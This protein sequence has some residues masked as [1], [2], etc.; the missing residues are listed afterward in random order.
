MEA[1]P[2]LR[3][4]RSPLVLI[5]VSPHS[6]PLSTFSSALDHCFACFPSA[7]SLVS[8]M[9]ES[10]APKPKHLKPPR[11]SASRRRQHSCHPEAFLISIRTTDTPGHT[12]DDQ[13]FPRALWREPPTGVQ[14]PELGLSGALSA[15]FVCLPQS[16]GR[17]ESGSQAQTRTMR[18]RVMSGSRGCL[19]SFYFQAA[20]LVS[21][22][23]LGFRW[24]GGEA[25]VGV[26]NRC[27]GFSAAV[28]LPLPEV[29][30]CR[31]SIASI[32]WLKQ[33]KHRLLQSCRSEAPR[34][35][36]W[37]AF[38]PRGALLSLRWVL[39]EFGSLRLGTKIHAPLLAV[40]RRPFPASRDTTSQAHAPSSIVKTSNRRSRALTL[41]MSEPLP[42]VTPAKPRLPG[43]V[44]NG[45]WTLKL[46]HL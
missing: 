5:S 12:T 31:L 22:F 29:A 10:T 7:D 17:Q 8:S 38:L 35:S 37:A 34:G 2:F 13:V 44:T 15:D 11:P 1:L 21:L 40:S 46:R 19:W 20:E 9:C 24:G 39:A 45:F 36:P 33:H 30:V 18:P 32:W 23:T 41:P 26:V 27:P 28:D 3:P 14:R 42:F 6:A 16:R 43:K 25:G 4:L